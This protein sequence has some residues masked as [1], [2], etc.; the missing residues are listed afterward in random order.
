RQVGVSLPHSASKQY[1]AIRKVARADLEPGDI[2]FF[3]S[4]LHHNSI[5][6]GN[7]KVVHA[8]QPG[9]VVKV[10][11]MSSFPYAGAGRP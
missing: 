10:T 8:P 5:Y 1:R 2:V 4:D 7:G 11:S 6:V 3:Y 9:D